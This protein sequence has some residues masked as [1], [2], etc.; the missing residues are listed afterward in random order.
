M[1]TCL[2]VSVPAERRGSSTSRKGARR[3]M[4]SQLEGSQG[5]TRGVG[6][7]ASTRDTRGRLQGT[8]TPASDPGPGPG[9]RSIPQGLH[10]SRITLITSS[11]LNNRPIPTINSN[12]HRGLSRSQT[13]L[14]LIEIL[15]PLLEASV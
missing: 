7:S 8:G 5:R 4:T 11:T 6:A 9:I 10:R 3:S 13:E 12:R 1:S 14:A 15:N 2:R